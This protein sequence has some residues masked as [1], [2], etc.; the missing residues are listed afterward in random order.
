MRA[1]RIGVEEGGYRCV[2][3]LTE[4]GQV[5]TGKVPVD[6]TSLEFDDKSAAKLLLDVRSV[7][8]HPRQGEVLDLPLLEALEKL[9]VTGSRSSLS[10]SFLNVL[11][12]H[13][14]L[15]CLRASSD[16]VAADYA[17]Y[18]IGGDRGRNRQQAATMFP[19]LATVISRRVTVRLAVDGGREIYPALMS[20]TGAK[21]NIIKRL[22][23][24]EEPAYGIDTLDLIREMENVPAD[25]IPKP[26]SEE[27]HP[28]V[29]VVRCGRILRDV[30]QDPKAD[31]YQGCGGKWSK[32]VKAMEDAVGFEASDDERRAAD[33]L[34]GIARATEDMVRSFAET[35]V[36]PSAAYKVQRK[37][38]FLNP[39][40]I[41][42]GYAQSA[43]ILFGGKSLAAIFE[44]SH[45][46][47]MHQNRV[48]A[49]IEQAPAPASEFRR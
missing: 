43:R 7:D 30:L 49:Q 6:P 15:D 9:K 25:W 2:M 28:F 3:L 26:G 33:N 41:E 24:I 40:N 8:E 10:E 4:S 46:W 13:S 29:A 22:Q 17:F 27:W 37:K 31:L 47:H 32:F 5:F 18:A 11:M 36:L 34:E 48:L 42:S 35:V 44:L 16:A 1:G 20:A 39:Q 14:A 12:D 19:L 23:G 38:V 45:R 21:K